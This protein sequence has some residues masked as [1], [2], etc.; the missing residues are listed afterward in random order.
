MSRTRNLTPRV[1]GEAAPAAEAAP[2]ATEPE[3]PELAPEIADEAAPAA[4]AEPV[5]RVLRA[6]DVDPRKIAAPVLTADGWVMPM[7]KES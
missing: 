2:Q 1:P 7:P 4:D 3:A 5:R 6:A